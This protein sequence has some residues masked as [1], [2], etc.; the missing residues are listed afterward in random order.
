MRQSERYQC[1]GSISIAIISH[2]RTPYCSESIHPFLFFLF[3]FPIVFL[4]FCSSVHFVHLFTI[5]HCFPFFSNASTWLELVD[6]IFFMV[7]K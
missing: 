1:T 5:F 3:F 7:D 4:H 6:L 2:V